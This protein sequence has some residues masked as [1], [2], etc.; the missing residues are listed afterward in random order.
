MSEQ[1]TG[2]GGG[3][4]GAAALCPDVLAGLNAGPDW[5]GLCSRESIS[6]TLRQA[7]VST[8]MPRQP[9]WEAS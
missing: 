4:R 8:E 7:R 9:R 5:P 1:E 2:G 6:Q 3:G